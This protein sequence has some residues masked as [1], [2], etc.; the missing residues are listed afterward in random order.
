MIFLNPDYSV[1]YLGVWHSAGERFE[2][3]P[4][5]EDE[6]S[7]HGKIIKTG[8]DEIPSV[9]QSGG[10]EESEKKTPARRKK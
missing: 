9:P 7:K 10:T 8:D 4:A 1:N 2:I 5:D 3:S 6:L